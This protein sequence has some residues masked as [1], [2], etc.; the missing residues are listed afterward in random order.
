[1]SKEISVRR[2]FLDN[3][4]NE[5]VIKTI[6]ATEGDPFKLECEAPAGFPQP[7]IFWLIQTVQGSIKGID[8]PRLT[9]DPSGNLW[10][11]TVQRE[12]ASRDSYYVCSAASPVVNE[13]KLG[14][15]IALKVIP[16]KNHKLQRL[17][18]VQ[19]VSPPT[20]VGM[21]D[22]PVELFCIYHGMPLPNITWS[23][24]GKPIES[25]DRISLENYGKSL[26]IKKAEEADEGK[27]SCCASSDNAEDDS[28]SFEVKIE[29]PPQVIVEP[30]S[31]NVS[32][33][34]P[35]E[36]TCKVA[37]VPEPKISWFFNGKQIERADKHIQ[38]GQHEVAVKKAKKS[39]TGNYACIAINPHGSAYR[40]VYIDVDS[41]TS[42]K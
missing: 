3:F 41:I 20:V 6:E 26:K 1:M 24:D 2:V 28:S 11:S 19:Y 34:Q 10:F 16:I 17:P 8:N 14:N 32:L 7:S 23:K 4:K 18:K 27:Y 22:K 40:N 5:S 21:R 39:D 12:D 29:S 42:M 36:I 38:I 9:L 25:N 35:F 37:G 31:R 33:N 13:Y 15:R 30:T